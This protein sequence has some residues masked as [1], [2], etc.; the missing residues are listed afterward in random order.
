MILCPM[1]CCVSEERSERS[2]N[3]IVLIVRYDVDSQISLYIMLCVNRKRG[4]LVEDIPPWVLTI[5]VESKELAAFLVPA[6]LWCPVIRSSQHIQ[7]ERGIERQG[8]IKVINI[9]ASDWD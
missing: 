4:P 9:C 2:D 3:R 7:D 8:V 5:E 6:R 1:T